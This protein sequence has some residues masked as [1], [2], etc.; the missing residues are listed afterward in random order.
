G[1]MPCRS[2]QLT[3]TALLQSKL[4]TVAPDRSTRANAGTSVLNLCLASTG[5]PPPP[6]SLEFLTFWAVSQPAPVEVLMGGKAK[7]LPI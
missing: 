1:S 5:Q 6:D 2:D 7:V 4:S 3:E